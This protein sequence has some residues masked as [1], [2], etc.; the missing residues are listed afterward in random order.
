MI[1]ENY[2]QDVKKVHVNTVAPRAYYVPQAPDG[3]ERIRFLNGT[4]EFRYYDSIYDLTEKFWEEGFCT[5]DF[6]KVTV[7]GVW[8]NYGYDTHQYTNIRYPFPLDPPY[9]PHD[10]PCGAYVCRFQYKKDTEAPRAYLNFEGVDSCFYLWLNGRF[11]GYSQVSHS[12]SEFDVTEYVYEGENKLA[13]L[14]LK[15]CD[16]SYLEDQDKFR[17]SGIFRDVYLLKRPGQGI[18]DYFITTA[19]EKTGAAVDIR[20]RFF[21]QS[22]PV[23]VTLEDPWGKKVD[24]VIVQ[25]DAEE[26]G[27]GGRRGSKPI[28]RPAAGKEADAGKAEEGEKAGKAEEGERAEKAEW[29]R[30]EEYQLRICLTAKDPSLWNPEEPNLYTLTM[31]TQGEIIREKV[32]IR[33]IAV[34]NNTVYLNGNAIKFKGVNRHDFDPVTGFCVSRAQMK[35]DLIL[36]KEHNFNAI[37]TSHYP[38]APYF[39]QLCDRYGFMVIDEADNESHGTQCQFLKDS[40]WENAALRWNE[41]IADN[42][43]YTEAVLDRVQRCVHRDKNRPCVV[44]W[45]M[46]NECAYGCTFEEALKWTKAFDPGRLTHYES[47]FYRSRK[48]KYDFSNID[49][50]S[51]MYPSLQEIEEYL[52]SCPDKPYLM[53]EYCHSMGNGPG[54]FE[55]Y[56]QIINSHDSMCGGFVWEW[57]DHGI[58]KGLTEEGRAMYFYGGDHGEKLHDGNFCMDGLVYPDRSAHTGLLEY[59]NVHRPARVTGYDQ[60]T[61]C[62]SLKNHMDF[63]NLKDYIYIIYEVLCDGK[64]TAMGKLREA[65][66]VEPHGEGTAFLVV[67]VPEKGKCYLKLCYCLKQETEI[68]VEGYMLGFDEIPLANKDGRNQTAAALLEGA[69]NGTKDHGDR[70]R[71]ELKVEE[72]DKYLIVKGSGFSCTY[73]RRTGLFA[74]WILGRELLSRPME[75]NI[76]RAPTDNDRKLRAEWERAY[77]DRAAARAYETNYC[78]QKGAVHIYSHISLAAPSIQR[79]LDIDA[80]WTVGQAGDITVAMDVKRDMEFP[81]LPRF[82]L[83]LFLPKEFDQASYYGL[84]PGESY[85]DKCRG[86]SHGLYKSAVREFHEDYLRPQENGSHWDC[87]YMMVENQDLKLAAVSPKPFGF[88]VSVYTQ[89]ELTKKRHNYELKECGNTVLCLDYRQN[90]IGSA[91]CGPELLEKYKLN[92]ERFQFDL[93]LVPVNK[94]T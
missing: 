87:D 93:R 73:D 49:L 67:P 86:T 88:N 52:A 72:T 74:S 7:P 59:K 62:L 43:D 18:F 89:E 2:Y 19:I 26:K 22:V 6:D 71:E 60:D 64:V 45:S 17:M 91:S 25:R 53:C 34:K 31:E 70:S 1:V 44:I 27:R 84:G 61:G 66:F 28:L 36:M 35:L 68:L 80:R 51:R 3:S 78:I 85:V 9:V 46:G 48:R 24:P 32:G 63:V 8:Q 40:E 20:I 38:N 77:Y 14:V 5:E 13:V 16:G 55:D 90:G 33:E 41:R 11:V 29:V 21:D 23:K 58:Y 42:P 81:E 56:F 54:D 92:E 57:C 37:R 30:A 12:V 50:Y 39:Y 4:W 47:A 10:N 76:W 65:P 79:I 69:G 15:W 94:R 82:G 83:R 75:M